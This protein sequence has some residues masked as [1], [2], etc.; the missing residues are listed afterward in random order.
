LQLENVL[1]GLRMGSLNLSCPVESLSGGQ[2]TRAALASI[3]LRDADIMLLDEPTNNLDLN[4]L[5][6]LERYL[7]ACRSTCLSLLSCGTDRV[8]PLRP[9]RHF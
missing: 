6:W 3:M 1:A 2:R 5:V 7:T 8:T 9:C 4:A